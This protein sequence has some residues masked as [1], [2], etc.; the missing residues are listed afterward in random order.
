MAK[1]WFE[2]L[3]LSIMSAESENETHRMLLKRVFLSMV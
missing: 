1:T 3:S 2:S